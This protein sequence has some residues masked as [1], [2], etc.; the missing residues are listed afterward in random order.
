LWF[1]SAYALLGSMQY[2]EPRYFFFGYLPIALWAGLGLSTVLGLIRETRL[3]AAFA[4][5]PVL[6]LLVLGYQ[7]KIAYRPDFG[8]LAAAYA[9]EIREGVVFVEADYD[10]SFVLAARSACGPGR[11]MVVR[12]SKLLYSC[13]SDVKWDF[14]SSVSSPADVDRLMKPFAFDL[15]FAERG[16]PLGLAEVDCLHAELADAERYEHVA[17]HELGLPAARAARPVVIDV[18]RMRNPP[19]RRIR[20]LEIPV[21]LARRTVHVTIQ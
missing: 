3:R 10:T 17:T 20:D 14:Q 2:K 11:G 13:S 6:G 16:N 4:C 19:A 7:T 8:P 9:S 12:G 5:L 1:V 18:Y 21:P 15:I